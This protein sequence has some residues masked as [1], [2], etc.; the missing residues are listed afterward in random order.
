MTSR[1][2]WE[3]PGDG[4]DDPFKTYAMGDA[5]RLPNGNTL[6][7]SGSL[8]ATDSRSRIMEITPDGDKVWEIQLRGAGDELAGCHMA[9]RIPVLVGE[10]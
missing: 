10:L 7:T 2:V 3:Y 8:I 1:I 5:D 9:E 6:V 4:V